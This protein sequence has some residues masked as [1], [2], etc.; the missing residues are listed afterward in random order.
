M[1]MPILEP[2]PIKTR[3]KSFLKK[4]WI[5]IT[6]VRKWKLVE[7][8]EYE[9]NGEKIVIPKD[10]IFDGASVPRIL[11]G[12]LSPTGLLLIQG[13]IHDFG[14]RYDYLWKVDPEATN[15]Y[16]KAYKN[17]GQKYWDKLFYKVGRDVNDMNIINYLAWT[18][19][20]TFGGFAWSANRKR[21]EK[22][23]NPY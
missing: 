2:I 3:G 13:L 9:L 10:F 14:Y 23:I 15:G 16:I 20:S 1:V 7:N 21:N 4:V 5:W 8:W 6:S 19:L 17:S 12:V 22:D 11:W 18:V